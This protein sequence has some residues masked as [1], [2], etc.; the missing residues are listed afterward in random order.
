[1]R[2]QGSQRQTLQILLL[3]NCSLRFQKGVSRAQRDLGRGEKGEKAVQVAELEDNMY[4]ISSAQ[5]QSA[6]K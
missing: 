3:W 2:Y 4:E 6:R 1:M 5:D